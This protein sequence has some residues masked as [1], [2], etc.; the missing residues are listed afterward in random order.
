MREKKRRDKL[1]G[2]LAKRPEWQL[3]LQDEVWWSRLAQPDLHTG[4]DDKSQ[5]KPLPLV[6]KEV[7][8][9]DTEPKAT[10]SYGDLLADTGQVKQGQK[11]NKA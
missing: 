8:K 4:T 3:A 1:K 10:A 11:K 9:T 5:D 2:L 6:E 7:A